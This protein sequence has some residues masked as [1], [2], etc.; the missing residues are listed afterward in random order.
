MRPICIIHNEMLMHMMSCQ[1]FSS[2]N[3]RRVTS[4]RVSN[5][6]GN[7]SQ[8]YFLFSL[9]ERAPRHEGSSSGNND[10]IGDLEAR[11]ECLTV[12]LCHGGMLRACASCRVDE[13]SAEVELC[14]VRLWNV[15]GL[16]SRL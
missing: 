16:L 10:P 5:G 15:I 3:T 6:K 9:I 8:L 14:S 12:E 2:R 1:S 13:L 4:F 11:V 7:T